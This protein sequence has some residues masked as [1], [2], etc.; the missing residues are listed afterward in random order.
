MFRERNKENHQIKTNEIA[1][2]ILLNDKMNYWCS[3]QIICMIQLQPLRVTD[4]HVIH[5]YHIE[6][7]LEHH[8]YM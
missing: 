1:T 8:I 6:H 2:H 7:E 3:L 4:D 5:I